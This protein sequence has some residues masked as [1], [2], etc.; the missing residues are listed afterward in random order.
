MIALTRR[1]ARMQ[2]NCI[3]QWGRA[4][5]VTT[6]VTVTALYLARWNQAGHRAPFFR[7]AQHRVS[8]WFHAAAGILSCILPHRSAQQQVLLT[9]KP[10]S[11]RGSEPAMIQ[12]STQFASLTRAVFEEQPLVAPAKQTPTFSWAASEEA[13]RPF[14]HGRLIKRDAQWLHSTR[15][16]ICVFTGL[17]LTAATHQFVIS[18]SSSHANGPTRAT[19]NTF[20]A[21]L[22]YLKKNPLG[23]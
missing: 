17:M 15:H 1:A 5:D 23:H 21:G 10:C 12:Q 6:D 18:F 9:P 2:R 19:A 3:P 22:L 13:A 7:W 8:F 4:T 11:A 20:C 16:A 14:W